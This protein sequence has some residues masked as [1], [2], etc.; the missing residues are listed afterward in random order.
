MATNLS[1]LERKVG[2]KREKF[3]MTCIL[4][5]EII[6]MVGKLIGLKNK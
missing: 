5:E 4:W 1:E 3:K 2:T 6:Q